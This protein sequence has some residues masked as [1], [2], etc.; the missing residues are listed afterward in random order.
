MIQCGLFSE[1]CAVVCGILYCTE[2]DYCVPLKCSASRVFWFLIAP[3]AGGI[4]PS[5]RTDMEHSLF[6]QIRYTLARKGW[7]AEASA[8][9]LTQLWWSREAVI[10]EM[11]IPVKEE[12]D[13]I[14]GQT[15]VMRIPPANHPPPHRHHLHHP[16]SPEVWRTLPQTS[17]RIL[18]MWQFCHWH[19]CIACLPI[20]FTTQFNSIL[21]YRCSP[22]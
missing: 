20:L 18:N 6:L 11:P 13:L 17:K 3:V 22:C 14:V 7:W 1:R 10:N 2:L 15:S 5:T 8:P 21:C 9:P 4:S 16:K 12:F 19:V